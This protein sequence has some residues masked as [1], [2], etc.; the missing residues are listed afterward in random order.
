MENRGEGATYGEAKTK[1][2]QQR[3]FYEG[4]GGPVSGNKEQ[5]TNRKHCKS[6]VSFEMN[7]LIQFLCQQGRGKNT[8]ES[9]EHFRLLILFDKHFKKWFPRKYDKKEWYPNFLLHKFRF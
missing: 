7:S 9:L 2:L 4:G 3:W 5:N 1:Y 6:T 8:K